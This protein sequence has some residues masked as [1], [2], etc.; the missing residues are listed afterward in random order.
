MGL[1]SLWLHKKP[2]YGIEKKNVSVKWWGDIYSDGLTK[3][4]KLSQL[5]DA[6]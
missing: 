4:K 5:M 3:R 1:K 6:N 2:R